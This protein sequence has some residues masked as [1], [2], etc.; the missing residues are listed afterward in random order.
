[1]CVYATVAHANAVVM[2]RFAFGNSQRT[3]DRHYYL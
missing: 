2:H 1:V 3:F